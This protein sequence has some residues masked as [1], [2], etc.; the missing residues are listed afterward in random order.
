MVYEEFIRRA[1]TLINQLGKKTPTAGVPAQ[2]HGKPEATV[3]YNNLPELPAA[4]F[5]Y[6]IVEEERAKLAL[7]LDRVIRES[8]PAD[9]Y[10]DD[11]REKQILNAI[12][13]I[14]ERDRNATEA[15]FKIIKEQRGYR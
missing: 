7:K 1:E 2:L 12:Y 5:Q 4:T 13:P 6:P 11:T 10:G 14:L 8:A 9:W 3:L 15:I